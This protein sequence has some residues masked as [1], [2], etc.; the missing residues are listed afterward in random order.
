M[1]GKF[2]DFDNSVGVSAKCN[3]FWKEKEIAKFFF[4][5]TRQSLFSFMSQINLFRNKV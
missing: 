1:N 3:F 5:E 2:L 4:D